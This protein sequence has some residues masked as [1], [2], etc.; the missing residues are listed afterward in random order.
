ME[1]IAREL[2]CR[3]RRAFMEVR[4]TDHR[5]DSEKMAER[6]DNLIEPPL[7]ATSGLG[8]Q[9]G[10]PKRGGRGRIGGLEYRLRTSKAAAD[11]FFEPELEGARLTVVLNEHHPFVRKAC[12][13]MVEGAK[14]S[15]SLV[16]KHLELLILAAA[17]TEVTL[18]KD[19]QAKQWAREFRESWSNILAKFLS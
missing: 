18:A 12:G 9:N 14:S 17:R 1:S 8:K 4:G 2:N 13:H 5:R 11:W 7:Q 19:N 16:E 3:A 15:Q 10:K 6:F